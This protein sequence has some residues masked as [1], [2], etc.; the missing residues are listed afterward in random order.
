VNGAA[1]CAVV[2][3]A[4]LLV[5]CLGCGGQEEPLVSNL[6]SIS[7]PEA[8]RAVAD[9]LSAYGGYGRWGS[10]RNVEYAY[11]LRLYG[12][13]GVEKAMTRQIHR[14]AL[15]PEPKGYIEDLAGDRQVVRLDGE[16]LV[17][18]RGGQPLTDPSVLAFPKAYLGMA[19]WSF[20]NPWNLLDPG[21][22]LEPRGVRT[23]RVAG[24]VPAGPCDVVRLRFDRPTDAG[25]TD[26][27]YDFYISRLTRL[28]EQVHSYRAQENAYRV[29]LWSDHRTYDGL[30]VASRR[31]VHASDE[32]GAIGR[33]EA[34]AEYSEVRFDAPFGDEIFRGESP[35]AAA[36]GG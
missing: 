33:L 11:T 17:V 5:C 31:E 12:A 1:R 21:T 7:E 3:A 16:R 26:D 28:V 18:T 22:R 13:G 27:W 19:R 9:M 24:I 10:K 29:S 2:L 25:G 6:R 35:L 30:R 32:N 20:M 34:V 4:G 8:R 23:P 36:A 14:F 15:G